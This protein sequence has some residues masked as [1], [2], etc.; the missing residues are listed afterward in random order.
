MPSPELQISDEKRMWMYTKVMYKR[1]THGDQ[2][3]KWHHLGLKIEAHTKNIATS[4]QGTYQQHYLTP[5]GDNAVERM[6]HNPHPILWDQS[7]SDA[8]PEFWASHFE[9]LEGKCWIPHL[10][11][12][13]EEHAVLRWLAIKLKDKTNNPN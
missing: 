6:I 7:A 4:K 11:R 3:Q 2:W 13:S 8:A 9:V 12:K 5:E 10:K 1:T